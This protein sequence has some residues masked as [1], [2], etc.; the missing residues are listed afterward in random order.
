VRDFDESR[1]VLVIYAA[2]RPLDEDRV[3]EE[4]IVQSGYGANRMAAAVA[5]A[6]AV[7]CMTHSL[8]QNFYTHMVPSS[9]LAPF[10]ESDPGVLLT[11][12][13]APVDNLMAEVFRYRDRYRPEQEREE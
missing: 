3:R 2:D 8:Q 12:Q 7:E 6:P 4:A 9:R 5:G 11:D 1:Q 13:Y 10:L